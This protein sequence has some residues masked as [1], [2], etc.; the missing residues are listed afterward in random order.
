MHLPCY[1]NACRRFRFGTCECLPVHVC[2]HPRGG[3]GQ[4][5]GLL[6]RFALTLTWG[7]QRVKLGSRH[8]RHVSPATALCCLW[9][10]RKTLWPR[11]SQLPDQT[12]HASSP[13]SSGLTLEA[14]LWPKGP[15]RSGGKV[16]RLLCS[17]GQRGRGTRLWGG[18]PRACRSGRH[19]GRSCA[20]KGGR[21][22]QVERNP[23]EGRKPQM[24][25][26]EGRC[27]WGRLVGTLSTSPGWWRV[28]VQG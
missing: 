19:P 22:L 20:F 2:V 24:E 7:T 26:E 8:V 21:V 14:A 28:Q 16:L 27:T 15:G 9:S 10:H 1:P 4:A 13:G 23:R 3:W 17:R 18:S 5:E 25:R 6:W 11:A 12:L